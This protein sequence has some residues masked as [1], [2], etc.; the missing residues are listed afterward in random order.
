[1]PA[2]QTLAQCIPTVPYSCCS[3]YRPRRHHADLLV[4][5]CE[6]RRC[7]SLSRTLR[8]NHVRRRRPQRR[9]PPVRPQGRCAEARRAGDPHA[10]QGACPGP[11]MR[12]SATAARLALLIGRT[13][14]AVTHAS[15]ASRCVRAACAR[16]RLERRLAPSPE[17]TRAPCSCTGWRGGRQDLRQ[18]HHRPGQQ[19]RQLRHP[20]KRHH[21]GKRPALFSGAVS[22][23]LCCL[24]RSAPAHCQPAPR[25]KGAILLRGSRVITPRAGLSA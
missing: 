11:T 5:Q 7:H 3:A 15:C 25:A 23:I 14:R 12:R 16:A 17:L 10:G 19:E 20:G 21:Q 9:C 18:R 13:A 8:S 24:P 4:V 6:V 2:G 1:M 22:A